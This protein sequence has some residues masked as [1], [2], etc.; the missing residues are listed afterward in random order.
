MNRRAKT[1][2]KEADAL[3]PVTSRLANN[4]RLQTIRLPKQKRGK[5]RF[6]TILDAAERLL[7]DMEP[8]DISIYQIAEEAGVSAQSIYHFF[9]DAACVYFALAEHFDDM[10]FKALETPPTER[11]TS[12]QQLLEDR[13]AEAGAFYNAHPAARKL[14]LG[15]GL[16]STIR[17]LDLK[18]NGRAAAR[19][20][21]ELNTY[22][23]MPQIPDFV[24]R[25]TETIIISDA[26][27]SLSVHRHGII[28]EE[29]HEQAKRARI[30][31]C[32]TFLPEYVPHKTAK[33]A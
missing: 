8:A 19:A 29:Y 2:K 4:S 28:T 26:I 18:F 16:S 25:L 17:A 9:P 12:W 30:A 27:W 1:K 13:F 23:E 10:F 3:A 14:I 22:F 24:E 7:E 15:T 33:R 5:E 20:I 32:R 11:P 6:K 31:Y 21:E